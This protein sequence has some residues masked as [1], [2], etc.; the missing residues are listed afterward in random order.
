MLRK[1]LTLSIFTALFTSCVQE[2]DPNNDRDIFLG[3]WTCNEYEGDFAPQTYNIEVDAFGAG[4]DVSIT[5]LYNQGNTFVVYGRVEGSTIFISTQTI[6]GITISGSGNM[7]ASF[8][9]VDLAFTADDGSGGDDIKA[10]W[11][12]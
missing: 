4:Q 3:N 7:A 11:L 1:Y 10:T 8:D 9:R 5:G 12:R 2:T 6:D